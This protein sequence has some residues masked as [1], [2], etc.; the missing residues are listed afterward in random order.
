MKYLP[1]GKSDLLISQINFGCMSLGEDHQANASILHH[2]RDNGINCFD[3]ADL[4]Q[5]GLNEE[6]V[7]KAF[8]DIRSSVIIATKVGNQWRS[9]GSGWTGTPPR[10]IY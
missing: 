5:H 3:T 4:Y 7:G 1:L 8:R 2:A 6:T 9:D 10:N